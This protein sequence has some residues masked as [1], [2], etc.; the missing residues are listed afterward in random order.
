MA[1][2]KQIDD[3]GSAFPAIDGP[4]SEYKPGMSLR[5][6]FAGQ[7]LPAVAR[8]VIT[9]E[10]SALEKAAAAESYQGSIHG[11]AAKVAYQYADAMIAARS[12]NPN[13]GE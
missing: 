8:S 7:V 10:R 9:V 6:W 11:F 2:K 3:G 4:P 12:S 5:D 13:S 1:E